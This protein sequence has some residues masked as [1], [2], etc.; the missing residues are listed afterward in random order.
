MGFWMVFPMSA[1]FNARVARQSKR[2]LDQ[3][4]STV[5]LMQ[6]VSCSNQWYGDMGSFSIV[7]MYTLSSTL[8]VALRLPIATGVWSNGGVTRRAA[9]AAAPVG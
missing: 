5:A 8:A 9:P 6:V 2:P 7:T 4:V 3:F 1:F